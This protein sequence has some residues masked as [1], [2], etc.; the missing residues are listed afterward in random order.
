MITDSGTNFFF[1]LN[2]L[3]PSQ[4]LNAFQLAII[5]FMGYILWNNTDSKDEVINFWKDISN[6]RG[7]EVKDLKTEIKG[8]YKSKDSLYRFKFGQADQYIEANKKLI[9]MKLKQ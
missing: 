4:K 6:E 5:L 9:Q 1:R 3:N 8:L 7:Q 2:S